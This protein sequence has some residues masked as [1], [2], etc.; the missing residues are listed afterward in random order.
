LRQAFCTSWRIA[1]QQMA[2]LEPTGICYP[3]T[4]EALKNW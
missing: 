4:L 3:E 1:F 2:G